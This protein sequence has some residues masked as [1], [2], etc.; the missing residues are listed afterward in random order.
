M[1]LLNGT[2]THQVLDDC[3]CIIA[4]NNSQYGRF[5]D[6]LYNCSGHTACECCA[7]RL[8]ARAHAMRPLLG[9][10]DMERTGTAATHLGQLKNN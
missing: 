1:V 7:Q 3:W 10:P 8:L 5:L 6:S 2:V 4:D 9:L